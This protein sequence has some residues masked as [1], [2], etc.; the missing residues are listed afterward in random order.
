MRFVVAEDDAGVASLVDLIADGD[1]VVI[2]QDGRP[3][4]RMVGYSAPPKDRRSRRR[5][6]DPAILK[7]VTTSL[8][9]MLLVQAV[10]WTV[11]VIERVC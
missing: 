7:I 5:D 11:Y 2:V 4:A 8:G 1:E 3:V 10:I 9:A 6:V